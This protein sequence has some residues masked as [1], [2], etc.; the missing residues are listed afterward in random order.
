M[1]S[2]SARSKSAISRLQT[3]LI[4]DLLIV[5]SAI[6]A[7]FYVQSVTP[8]GPVQTRLADL[9]ILP[10]EPQSGQ[11]FTISV[12]VTNTGNAPGY[13]TLAL[14]ID[15]SQE[16]NQTIQLS[17]SE[18]KIVEF[19]VIAGGVGNH[20]AQ[21][22]DLSVDFVVTRAL[23]SAL[24]QL[25]N[26]SINQTEVGV[27]QPVK[28][29]I[30]ASNVGE[31]TDND[32]VS[33]LINDTLKETQTIT[34][35]G[36][37]KTSIE[38]VV[39]ESTPG[40][41]ILKVGNLTGTLSVFETPPVTELQ[42]ANLIINPQTASVGG[43][44]SITVDVTN[45]GKAGGNYSLS[46]TINDVKIATRNF[47]LPSG[48][49]T[50]LAFT[51]NETAEGSYTV[52][53]G[54]LLGTFDVQAVV[55]KPANI[56]LSNIFINPLEAWPGD[57]VKIS[58]TATNF[59]EQTGKTKVSL[60]INGQAKDSQTIQLA[61]GAT[62]DVSFTMTA[63]PVGTYTVN[64]GSL[65]EDMTV[66]AAGYHTL[67]VKAQATVTF[68]LDGQD[69][70]TPYSAL[71]KVG[72]HTIVARQT[73]PTGKFNFTNWDDGSTS[74]TRTV[75]LEKSMFVFMYY[76]GG[77]SSCPSL[78]FWNGTDYVYATEVS[79][80]GWLGYIDYINQDGSVVFWRNN[81][82]DY[83]KL[84]PNQLQ[85]SN[86]YY[87]LTLLQRSDEIFYID[88][89]YMV[90]V[91]HP[92]S[93][94]V[95]S[96]SVEQYLDPNYMG[97]IYTVSK[98]MVTP[99][100]AV[101]Q[102]G[103]NVL[104]QIAKVDGIFTSGINGIDSPSWNNTQWNTLTLDLG[105]L[106]NAKQIKLVVRATV[107][108]GDPTVYGNW[109]NSFFAQP[110]PNGTQPT[111]QSYMEVKDASGNWVRV[112]DSRQFPLPP[113]A[114]VPDTFVVD[115]TGLFPT[116]DYEL[117][118]NNFWNVTFDYIGV[119]T[120]AQQNVSIQRID[121]QASLYQESVTSSTA[122]GNFTRYGDV[123][124][125][126]LNADDEFVIGKQGDA[127]SLS[128]PTANLAPL[129]PGMVRD[130]FLFEACWFKDINGNWG[131]GFG[132]TADP[133]PFHNMSGFP[134]PLDTESYPY[135]AAHLSYLQQYNTRVLNPPNQ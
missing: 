32:S 129:A 17:G 15:N 49:T 76:N 56:V 68:S 65:T 72:P 22:N 45:T 74:L 23:L 108:W 87:N 115:L 50:T 67:A 8:L 110:V 53:I 125:L 9:K 58:A 82:W 79:D 5:S 26:F 41:Y 2:P 48:A 101:N 43:P 71:L 63:G 131:Y 39:T 85:T 103:E 98:N 3:F 114:D 112:P 31:Q 52:K 90:A 37:G 111:P 40:T 77:T 70:T 116:N 107:D 10:T 92:A 34:L 1:H 109:L 89:A 60:T 113:H 73:D 51:V 55:G 130:Y 124:P 16:Q 100:S 93:S 12:N 121:P 104:P 135:D 118:I 28:I 62:A 91:D 46:L 95:Y 106:T 24:F 133:L 126:V 18:S 59:G 36:G 33:L 132:F 102:N 78:Y 97:Q 7:F 20:T 105:N 4:I 127:V 27:N 66:V 134:Y 81:P 42:L 122:S 94:D 14:T 64:L 38:F 30:V 83:I 29:A 99:I 19:N 44:V 120:S 69:F 117:R 80:H 6:A 61:G 86:G 88:S 128:F 21:V 35:A 11:N 13:G 123:T 96:T 54:S 57:S 84:D 119:D 25:S 47:E 75:D